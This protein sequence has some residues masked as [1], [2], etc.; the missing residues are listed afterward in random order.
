M[1]G[2]RWQEVVSQTRPVETDRRLVYLLTDCGSTTTKAV[3]VAP[4]GDSYRVVARGEAPTTVEAPHADVIQGVLAAAGGVAEQ[5]GRELLAAD[6]TGFRKPATQHGGCDKY[7]SASSAGGGLQMLVMGVVRSLTAASAERAALGAGAIVTGVIAANEERLWA[8]QVATL[9]RLRPDAILLGGGVD[10]GSTEQVIRLAEL[11]AA[12]SPRP[13]LDRSGK[14]PVIFAGNCDARSTV[15]ELLA[16]S[17]ELTIIDNIR[18]VL[19]VENLEPARQAIYSVFMDHVM[20][21]APGYRGLLELCDAPL[22]P[23]PAAVGESIRQ[24]ATTRPGDVLA[25]DIGGATTDVFSVCQGRFVRSV[26]ANIGMSYSVAHVCQEVGLD[27]VAHWLPMALPTGELHNRILNKM[28]RPTTIP[29]SVTGLIIEHAVAREALRL[30]LA[31]HQQTAAGLQG[32]QISRQVA[33]VFQNVNPDR[34]PVDMN[35]VERIIGSG[36]ILVNAP[37]PRQ[38]AQILIDGLLPSGITEI[39]LDAKYLLPHLGVLATTDPTAA[40]QVLANDCLLIVGVCVAPRADS[41]HPGQFLAHCSLT[42]ACAYNREHDLLA[43]ELISL[44]LPP[45]TEAILRVEPSVQVDMGVGAGRKLERAVEGGDCGVVL[46][47]R[48]RPQ[49]IWSGSADDPEVNRQIVN[50]WYRGLD[51]YPGETW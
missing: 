3:L 24:L 48:G 11:I 49:P 14:L 2:T 8:E 6:G 41:V 16:E 40:R 26:S 51:L 17:T 28:I 4:L 32:I 15:T 47:G 31:Q 34:E 29:D 19:E 13:R 22:L 44:E 20:A 33:E 5:Y 36:G 43:G 7:L 21:C 45:G 12:A 25:V 23:T 35:R 9:K 27:A 46:D 37:R 38:A 39:A 10:G 50:R 18:P 1:K 30:A 42:G